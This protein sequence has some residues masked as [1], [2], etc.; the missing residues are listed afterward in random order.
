MLGYMT[1]REARAQ[2]F[3]H[4]AKY[5]GIPCWIGEIESEAPLLC[6]K[7]A[8]LEHLMPLWQSLEQTVAG[9][10]YPDEEPCFRFLVGREICP[11]PTG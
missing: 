8:P 7:W 9:F 3:T 5:F 4:H 2:G 6:T 1:A 10:L 11:Q